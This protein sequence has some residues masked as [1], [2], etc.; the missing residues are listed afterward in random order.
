MLLLARVQQ[1]A[2]PFAELEAL[3]SVVIETRATP[4]AASAPVVLKIPFG[5]GAGG[6]AAAEAPVP[7]SPVRTWRALDPMLSFP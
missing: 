2:Y 3:S 5:A 4:V 7:P 6:S 1:G